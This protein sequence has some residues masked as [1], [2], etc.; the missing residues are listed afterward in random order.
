MSHSPSPAAQP[1][2]PTIQDHFMSLAAAPLAAHIADNSGQV[3][4]STASCPRQSLALQSL[5]QAYIVAHDTATR[6][7]LGQPL[8]VTL[9]TNNGTAVIQTGVIEPGKEDDSIVASVVAPEEKMAEARV[10]SWGVD[11]VSKVVSKVLT[12]GKTTVPRHG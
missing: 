11:N 8:R 6:M 4:L 3:I 7:G 10:A 9:T 1:A 5:S 2:E 12:E